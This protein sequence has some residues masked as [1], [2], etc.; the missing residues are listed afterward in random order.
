M[1]DFIDMTA[2][3]KV[4]TEYIPEFIQLDL[5]A[6]I[7]HSLSSYIVTTIIRG[8]SDLNIKSMC[9]L[10]TGTLITGKRYIVFPIE[11]LPNR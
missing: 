2:S 4:N 8:K 7:I 6:E 1:C 10:L 3:M 5:V 9:C 11:S